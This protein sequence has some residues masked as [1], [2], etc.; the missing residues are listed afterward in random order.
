MLSPGAP[1]DKEL[2]RTIN[3][4]RNKYK[5]QT[6]EQKPEKLTKAL[7]VSTFWEA[8]NKL[9][10]QVPAHIAKHG[11]FADR[12]LLESI[13][14]WKFPIAVANIR[15]VSDERI[16]SVTKQAFDEDCAG[17]AIQ[18]L[19]QL[20]GIGHS[21]AGAILMFVNSHRYTVMDPRATAALSDLGYWDLAT[22]ARQEQYETYC[23]RC[24]ELS[25]RTGHSL[26]NVDRAL[27]ILG[28]ED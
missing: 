16:E 11:R 13:A 28:G 24:Q 18:Q 7:S 8:E 21:I 2:K 17:P 12:D 14:L 19:C 25:Q 23:L 1:S 9:L 20:N 10:E 6:K 15:E 5:E 22:E 4:S 3:L 27:F 26:R